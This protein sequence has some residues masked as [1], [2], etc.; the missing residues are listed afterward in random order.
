[1][2]TCAFVLLAG[3][4]GERLG[5]TGIKVGL[6][7]EVTQFACFASTDVQILTRGSAAIYI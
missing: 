2:H 3:G 5:Y 4:L 6:P 1:M 7:A